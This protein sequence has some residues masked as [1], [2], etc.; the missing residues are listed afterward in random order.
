MYFLKRIS[1]LCLL[2]LLPALSQAADYKAGKS[3]TQLDKPIA[4]QSGDKIEVLEFFWYGCPHC[5]SFEP[6][7]TKWLKKLPENVKFIRVPAPLNPRWMVHT[8]TYYALQIMGEGEKQHS[9]IFA[10]MH[11]KKKK[12]RSK[13]E[14]AD[15]LYTLGVD[16]ETFLATYD[17]FA[18]E[19][20]VNQAI[21]LGK[22]YRV[23][24]V[25]ELTINGKYTI[26]GSQA[27]SY[28]EMIKIAD[29]LIK[30]ESK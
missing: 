24:G 2:F 3:Y 13:S 11:I 18:V 5:F 17:S 16:K 20:R 9:E 27:G 8:R 21:K 26:S 6:T 29:Y 14:V 15:Y 25:P 28:E 22:E 12:L 7:I 4:T 10:A 1:L 30:K 23:N 19:M